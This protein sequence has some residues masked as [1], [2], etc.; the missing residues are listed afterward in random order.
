MLSHVG[1]ETLTDFISKLA[2]ICIYSLTL[3]PNVHAPASVAGVLPGIEHE[4]MTGI[5]FRCW[6]AIKQKQAK[7]CTT[8]VVVGSTGTEIG[9]MRRP[10]DK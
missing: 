7:C 5:S 9:L 4:G 3:E 10:E 6:F 1:I 2:V 8:V